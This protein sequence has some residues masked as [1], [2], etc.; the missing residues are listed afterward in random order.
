[1]VNQLPK[2]DGGSLHI[3]FKRCGYSTCCCTM[4]LLHG[5]YFYR[6]WREA[7]RQRKAYVRFERLQE[8]LRTI[9]RDRSNKVSVNAIRRQLRSVFNG[10]I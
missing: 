10:E 2:N 4:G 6:H 8:V 1:M 5:P 7:G 9:Q 3:E